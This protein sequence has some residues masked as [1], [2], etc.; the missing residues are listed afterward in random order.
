MR[1]NLF[2]ILGIL[3]IVV[4]IIASI[5]YNYQKKLI[6]ADR[7]NKQYNEYTENQV[8]GSQLMTLI[9]KVTD[10]NEKNKVAKDEKGR[11]IQNS[12]NS[13]KIEIKFL[14]SKDTYEMEAISNLG[15]EAFI[16]NYNSM[17][18]KCTKKEYHENTKQIKYMLFEQ[19]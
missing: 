9:N 16:K 14:E 17:F 11:Y 10:Q 5:Y 2:I 6:L 19:I 12:E 7:I 18:F 1:K 4:A 3:L 15:S 13:I 8:I